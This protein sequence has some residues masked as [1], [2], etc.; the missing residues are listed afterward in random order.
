MG[1]AQGYPRF[2]ADAELVVEVPWSSGLERWSGAEW[3]EYVAAAER[4]LNL[5][6]ARLVECPPSLAEQG[7]SVTNE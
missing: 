7:G 6:T 3:N 4:N 5:V 2:A 1:N